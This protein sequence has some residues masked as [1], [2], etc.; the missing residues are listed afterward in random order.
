MVPRGEWTGGR[1]VVARA[2][3]SRMPGTSAMHVERGKNWGHGE[4]RTVPSLV[5][6]AAT[7]GAL[8]EESLGG[9]VE[10]GEEGGQEGGE[11]VEGGTRRYDTKVD[12]RFF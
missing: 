10:E 7:C 3:V 6:V 5:A 11:G 8:E 4:E 1:R 12:N 2:V 9:G